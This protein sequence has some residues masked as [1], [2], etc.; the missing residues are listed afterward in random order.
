[1][2]MGQASGTAAALAVKTG[3]S[4]RLLDTDL[5]RKTLKEN[6]VYLGER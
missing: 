4:L 5:L 6:G 2:A 1:M 3:S